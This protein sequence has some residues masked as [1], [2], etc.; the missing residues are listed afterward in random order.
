MLRY[1][2]LSSRLT[3]KVLASGEIPKDSL[4][5]SWPGNREEVVRRGRRTAIRSNRSVVSLLCL[6]KQ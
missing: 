1:I 6:G 3:C 4:V 2:I 5:R